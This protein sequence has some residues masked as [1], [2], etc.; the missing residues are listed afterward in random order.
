MQTSP[1][2]F[3]RHYAS[4]SDEALLDIDPAELTEVA[5][6]CLETELAE[7]GLLE[8]DAEEVEAASVDAGEQP[9][10][11]DFGDTSEWL[12]DAV[13]ACSFASHPGS[14]VA[15]GAADACDALRAAGIPSNI[16]TGQDSWDEGQTHRKLYR[17]M[18]PGPLILY[19]N[20]VLDKEL[21][22][23]KLETTWRTH[24][25]GLS[26]KDLRSLSPE[27]M[28]AGYADLIARLKAAYRDEIAKRG[29]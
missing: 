14:S 10:F 3:R 2:E 8:T 15:D 4:L 27:R 9:D 11:Q 13:E 6:Q 28:C 25:S 18:V 23:V 17:V 21:F 5:Q 20:A 1:Q 7:R 29:S 22:N 26:D 19:A 12:E 24:F 16:V